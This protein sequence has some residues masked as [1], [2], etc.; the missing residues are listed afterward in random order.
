MKTRQRLEGYGP[1]QGTRGG[2]RE[3]D[4]AGRTLPRSSGGS[5]ALP[6]LDLRLGPPGWEGGDSCCFKPPVC[7]VLV[8]RP[9]DAPTAGEGRGTAAL[10]GEQSC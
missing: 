5:P 6:H 1:N 4:E 7:A 8:Q 2:P 3:L 10:L 9:R